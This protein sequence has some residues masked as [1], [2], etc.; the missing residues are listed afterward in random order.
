M[1]K[2]RQQLTKSLLSISGVTEKQ[3]PDRDDG[4]SSFEYKGKDFA[5]FHHDNEID[6]KLGKQLIKEQRVPRP[7]DSEPHPNRA[8]GS[9]WI[10]L[11]YNSAAEVD[12]VVRLIKL[13]LT[14][15]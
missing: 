3:W 7:K 11:R 15:F 9:P 12:E 14:Q 13:G 5:H 1:N 6:V 10:E 8:A 2:L 4:F